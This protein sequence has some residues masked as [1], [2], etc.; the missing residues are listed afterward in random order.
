MVH[1]WYCTEDET[2]EKPATHG[3]QVPARTVERVNP[4]R[5]SDRPP[6]GRGIDA[7]ALVNLWPGC[8]GL[9]SDQSIQAGLDSAVRVAD[10]GW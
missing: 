3:S 6:V 7:E 8:P 5:A 1:F 4:D 10:S 2:R 9:S